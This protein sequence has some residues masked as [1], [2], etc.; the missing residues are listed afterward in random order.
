MG[1]LAEIDRSTERGMVESLEG[2]VALVTG[3][4]RGVGAATAGALDWRGQFG[5]Q[6][7]MVKGALK[8]DRLPVHAFEP[9]ARSHLPVRLVVWAQASPASSRAAPAPSRRADRLL[10][11]VTA[12]LARMRKPQV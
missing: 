8:L 7:L 11:L 12:C 3:A 2:K 9:Y 1:V 6:P 10:D 5:L 4:S